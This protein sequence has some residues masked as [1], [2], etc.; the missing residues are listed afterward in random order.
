M[1]A[2]HVGFTVW[3]ACFTACGGEHWGPGTVT[4][5]EAPAERIAARIEAQRAVEAS[6]KGEHQSLWGYVK[7]L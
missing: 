7:L 5:V 4:D 6:L 3:V 1:R 2:R